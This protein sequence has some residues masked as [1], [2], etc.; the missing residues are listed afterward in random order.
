M[1]NWRQAYGPEED[2]IISSRIRY[3][4]NLKG[5]NFPNFAGAEER[6]EVFKKLS[7]AIQGSW[8]NSYSCRK[9]KDIE[10]PQVLVENQL[11]SP[12]LIDNSEDSGFCL[13]QDQTINFLIN[14]EDHLKLQI[15]RPGLVLGQSLKEANQ[16]IDK[17]EESLDFAYNPDFGYLTSSATN[18]GT[19]LRA[20]VIM[21]L[22]GLDESGLIPGLRDSLGKLGI[23]VR[24]G[25]GQNT[26]YLYQISNQRTLGVSE[27]EAVEKLETIVSGI[28]KRERNIREEFLR[29]N[30]LDLEDL[31]FRSLGLLKNAVLLGEGE[32]VVALSLLRAG[33]SAGIYKG[34][35]LKEVTELMY[36]VKKHNINKYKKDLLL[37]GSE[38]YARSRYVKSYFKEV[39]IYGQ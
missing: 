1:T 2:V 38:E 32:A 12:E 15:I 7:G 37:G 3:G 20:S 11:I 8:P 19:G 28:A 35:S 16:L 9:L 30:R 6:Q 24:S 14:E 31:V 27:E 5:Y 34:L 21:H 23:V 18:T 39:E 25:Y 17:L 26:G 10:T 22:P 33:I 36:N 29:H 4:R 13:S